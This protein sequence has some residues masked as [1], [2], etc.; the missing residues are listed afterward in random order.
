MGW[1]GFNFWLA[2]AVKKTLFLIH[3]ATKSRKLCQNTGVAPIML[4]FYALFLHFKP[5]T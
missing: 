5:V 1:I 2:R 3:Q 4:I